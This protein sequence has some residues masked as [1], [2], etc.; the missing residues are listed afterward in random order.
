MH[1]RTILVVDDDRGVLGMLAD[2]LR[3]HGF[4]VLAAASAEEAVEACKRQGEPIALALLDVQLE[5]LDGPATL[6][7]LREAAPS[8]PCCFMS[9]NTGRYSAAGL[10]ALGA[11]RVFQKPFASIA[12]LAAALGEVIREAEEA[13]KGGPRGRQDGGDPC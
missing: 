4:A 7:A 5:C 2:A 11:P 1:R 13:G 9:G 6:R 3:L 10:L 8:L 12:G